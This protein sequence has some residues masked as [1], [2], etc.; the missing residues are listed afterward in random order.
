M[1]KY[2]RE[3]RKYTFLAIL[4]IITIVVGLLLGIVFCFCW[5]S[6]LSADV[7][8]NMSGEITSSYFHCGDGSADNPYVITTPKHLSPASQ[9]KI[10]ISNWAMTW[11]GNQG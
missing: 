6:V 8:M 7:P 11:M 9:K 3:I 10:T 1:G 5:L 2:S 4:T